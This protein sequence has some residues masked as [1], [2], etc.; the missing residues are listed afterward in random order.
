MFSPFAPKQAPTI[1][2]EDQT[3]IIRVHQVDIDLGVR[4]DCSKCPIAEAIFRATGHAVQV[5]A[6]CFTVTSTGQDHPL[7]ASA[8]HFRARFDMGQPVQPFTF[9]LDDAYFPRLRRSA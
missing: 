4:G 1:Y 5:W 6:I 8:R 2:F 3:M 9:E 7:P